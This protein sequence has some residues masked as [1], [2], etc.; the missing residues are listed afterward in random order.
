VTL[1]DSAVVRRVLAGDAEAFALLVDAHY[2]RSLRLAMHI[3]GT[4]EDAEDVVQD[5]F[6]RAYRHLERY[7]ERERF[8]AWLTRILVNQCRTA[9]ARR[10]RSALPAAGASWMRDESDR[11][12]NP[13]EDAARA[14]ELASAL[15]RLDPRQREAVALRFGAELSYDEMA[16]VTGAGVS[17]LKMR[18]RR[19]CARLRELLEGAPHV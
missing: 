19:A 2:E 18:V 8:A 16:A 12:E 6:L 17:A 11:D 4:R 5:T 1:S 13:A 9:L 7:E 14:A 10:R 3:V 15:A